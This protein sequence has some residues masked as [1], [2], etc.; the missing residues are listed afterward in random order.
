MVLLR[1]CREG[2]GGRQKRQHQHCATASGACLHDPKG[3]ALH[4]REGLLARFHH[5]Y[6]AP[7]TRCSISAAMLS[8]SALSACRACSTCATT[9]ARC[10]ASFSA[11]WARAAPICV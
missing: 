7:V 11:F 3:G 1:L 8:A 10:D 9:S 6:R 4:R 2:G 5:P